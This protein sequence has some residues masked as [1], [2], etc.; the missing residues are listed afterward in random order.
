M[1]LTEAFALIPTL[2][3]SLIIT[4]KSGMPSR[5]IPKELCP[6]AQGCEPVHPPQYCSAR[7]ASYP[8]KSSKPCFNPK[9]VVAAPALE[10]NPGLCCGIPLGF[11]R[12][13]TLDVCH[14]TPPRHQQPFDFAPPP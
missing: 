13:L 8:G 11:G 9:R 5:A 4:H 10:C 3:R 2:A 12:F 7:R 6:P 1:Q 14:D